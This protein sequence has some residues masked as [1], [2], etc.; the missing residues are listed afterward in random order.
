MDPVASPPI[1]AAP[2]ILRVSDLKANH[3]GG[4]RVRVFLRMDNE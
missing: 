1:Q 4:K 2:R 3:G